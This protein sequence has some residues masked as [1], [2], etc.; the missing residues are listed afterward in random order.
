MCSEDSLVITDLTIEF[1]LKPSS[2]LKPKHWLRIKKD[3]YLQTHARNTAWLQVGQTTKEEL[4]S[5]TLVVTNIRIG[6]PP[7]DSK[8]AWESRP[9]DLWIQ[10]KSY[11]GNIEKVFMGVDVL[12]GVDAV[13]ARPQWNILDEPLKL[14]DASPE[15][16]TARL[17]LRRG[18]PHTKPEPQ[19]LRARDDG[20]FKIVQISDTHMVTGVGTCDDAMDASG[21]SLPKS[22][23]DPLTVKF[24]G[25]I[26]DSEKPDLVLLTGDQPHHG[27]LDSQTV[28]LKVMAPIIE[29]YIP[30]AVVFGNHDDEG[31][32]AL[33]R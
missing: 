33:S 14:E 32:F 21:Q 9:T 24:I 12:F 19:T 15:T 13:D 1:V 7:E 8:D 16:P 5:T 3:L 17:T 10:R 6:S 28:L 20:S 31:D 27:I 11:T 26:L 4:T 2:G 18:L 22:E 25:S 30:W 23:A 29:R